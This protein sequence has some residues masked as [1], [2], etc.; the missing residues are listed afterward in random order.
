MT[1]G[2]QHIALIDLGLNGCN[3]KPRRDHFAD[4]FVFARSVMKFQNNGVGLAAFHAWMRG[5]IFPNVIAGKVSHFV[6]ARFHVAEM[7]VFVVHVPVFAK[8]FMTFPTSGMADSQSLVS[9][10][11]LPFILPLQT[12]D[13][14]LHFSPRLK[15]AMLLK[16][17]S[18]TSR[19][20]EQTGVRLS[21]CD[22]GGIRTL[23][24]LLKRQLLCR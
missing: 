18:L 11:K 21:V 10:I 19:A 23:N 3:G 22:L 15:R 7:M 14:L 20:V 13:A 8:R 1:V 2:A 16:Q 6:L 9:E 17:Q 12:G 24:Q 4:G 5:Q